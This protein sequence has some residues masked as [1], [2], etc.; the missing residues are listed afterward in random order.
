[1]NMFVLRA[2]NYQRNKNQTK[3]TR[4]LEWKIMLVLSYV[5]IS[6]KSNRAE[7]I[8][9]LNPYFKGKYSL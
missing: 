8:E 5:R 9:K 6:C 2:N 1:M 7:E 4:L 3:K